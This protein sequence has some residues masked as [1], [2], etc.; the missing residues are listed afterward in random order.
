M[1]PIILTFLDADDLGQSELVGLLKQEGFDPQVMTVENPP[2]LPVAQEPFAAV[3]I[4]GQ[5]EPIQVDKALRKLSAYVRENGGKTEHLIACGNKLSLSDERALRRLGVNKVIEPAIWKARP[6]A[7]RVLAALLGGFITF[8]DGVRTETCI[9]FKN[10]EKLYLECR[11]PYKSGTVKRRIIGPT[12]S[13]RRL[14]KR[15]EAYSTSPYTVLIRGNTG[16]GKEL[17]AAAIHSL[18]AA[19]EGKEYIPI[20]IAEIPSDL[21][22]SELFGHVRGAFTDARKERQGLLAE[23][24]AG[25]VLIDEVGDLDKI[26]QTRLLRIVE[27]REIRRVGAKHEKVL[28][29]NA[30]LI[31]ATNRDLE[32]MCF[33]GEF[34]QDLY[35]RIKEGHRLDVPSL[36][37]RKGDLEL[38]VKEI[39]NKWSEDWSGHH[40]DIFTLHQSD[41]D[42]IVDLCIRHEFHGNVRGLWGILRS[43]FSDSL[44]LDQRFNLDQLKTEI[45]VDLK[46]M[47]EHVN[48]KVEGAATDARMP[49]VT[50]DP[51]KDSFDEFKQRAFSKY[52]TEVYNAAG[53]DPERAQ[54]VAVVCKKTLYNYLPKTEQRRKK[55]RTTSKPGSEIKHDNTEEI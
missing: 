2:V 49:S 26:N 52:F 8:P 3:L 16:T 30:R 25:T 35:H 48:R 27:S 9:E 29:L 28:P 42:K 21:V 50:F 54:I 13:M 34:R 11:V 38:L 44:L 23:A 36:S 7:E 14:F 41:Y 51:S 32:K 19:N 45:E 20:N 18:N 33:M 10:G 46:Q 5:F 43:C 15:I 6:V 12:Q 1:N 4:L 55:R 37:E 47:A 39:F 31:F 53:K 22:A 40:E 24:G 17:V